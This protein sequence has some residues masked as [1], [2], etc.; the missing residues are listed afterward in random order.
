[1]GAALERRIRARADG[2]NWYNP[3]AGASAELAE[4]SPIAVE[5]ASAFMQTASQTQQRG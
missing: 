4:N 3:D 2:K 5:A 1:M